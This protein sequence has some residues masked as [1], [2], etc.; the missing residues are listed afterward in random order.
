M[1]DERLEELIALAHE[2][3][4]ERNRITAQVDLLMSQ[5]KDLGWNTVEEAQRALSQEKK[6][7]DRKKRIFEKKLNV[8]E[9]KYAE[10][11]E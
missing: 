5:L 7:L 4:R 1:N 9:K 3:E 8:F 11:L 2:H 6:K 10:Y